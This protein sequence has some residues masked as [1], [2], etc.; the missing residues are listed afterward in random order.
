MNVSVLPLIKQLI[1]PDGASQKMVLFVIRFIHCECGSHTGQKDS[2]Y[3]SWDN[4]FLFA[5]SKP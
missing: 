5:V 3:Y 4:S 2:V 1:F